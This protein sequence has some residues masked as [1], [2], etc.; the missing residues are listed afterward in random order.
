MVEFATRWGLAC[1]EDIEPG[2]THGSST[3][4]VQ[5]RDNR[6]MDLLIHATDYYDNYDNDNY[7]DNDNSIYHLIHATDAHARSESIG[8][9]TARERI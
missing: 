1:D 4:Q 5:P 6:R 3:A 8:D 2:A 9:E 7:N